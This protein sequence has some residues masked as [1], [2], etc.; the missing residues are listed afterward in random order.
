M[1]ILNLEA[2]QRGIKFKS[3]QELKV[4]GDF[5]DKHGEELNAATDLTEV[6]DKNRSV[7]YPDWRKKVAFALQTLQLGK[8]PEFNIPFLC[9]EDAQGFPSF[10]SWS[11]VL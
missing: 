1:L 7:W 8:T 6:S 4:L 3:I 10:L 2:T 5:P 9:F 11:F